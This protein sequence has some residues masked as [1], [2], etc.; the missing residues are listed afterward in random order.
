MR[1]KRI[2]IKDHS[3]LIKAAR[4]VR[5]AINKDK[6]LGML[7]ML[8]PLLAM[9]EAGFELNDSMAR[10]VRKRIPELKLDEGKRALFERVKK[11]EIQIPWVDRITLR[12]KRK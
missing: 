10:H 3:E 6:K 9:K 12:P 5:L 11:G 7:F 2:I 4:K 8:N 1:T